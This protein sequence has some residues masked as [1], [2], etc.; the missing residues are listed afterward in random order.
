MIRFGRFT[1]SIRFQQKKHHARHK[2]MKHASELHSIMFTFCESRTFNGFLL[3]IILLN[4]LSLVAQTW[5]YLRVRGGEYIG[6]SR[7]PGG[8]VLLN[9]SGKNVSE[10]RAISI[11]YRYLLY[12]MR[13]SV[14]FLFWKM[15]YNELKKSNHRIMYRVTLYI[16]CSYKSRGIWTSGKKFC[17]HQKLFDSIRLC[18]SCRS[19]TSDR[20]CFFW[21]IDRKLIK[22]H[23]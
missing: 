4:T 17:A 6:V 9:F 22:K 18:V 5:E 3:F 16:F 7:G 19:R 11:C 8:A 21:K 12:E 13:A 10:I 1:G 23:L 14:C 20:Q 2:M 15:M